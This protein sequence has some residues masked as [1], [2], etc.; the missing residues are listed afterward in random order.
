M[1]LRMHLY[2][3]TKFE[4]TGCTKFLSKLYHHHHHHHHPCIIFHGC[5][6]CKKH[7]HHHLCLTF[8]C[9]KNFSHKWTAAVEWTVMQ[10]GR[11]HTE[12]D[13]DSWSNSRV[14]NARKLL[15]TMNRLFGERGCK[16][17]FVLL[18]CDF[19]CHEEDWDSRTK[20]FVCSKVRRVQNSVT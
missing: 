16:G 5:K 6:N 15:K 8:H 4:V 7:H 1:V 17:S 3:Q 11:L 18:L 20:G 10:N 13:S 9:C 12:T 2:T 19:I 14:R